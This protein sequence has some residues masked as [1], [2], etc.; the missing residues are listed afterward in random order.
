MDRNKPSV[1]ARVLLST[2]LIMVLR[3]RRNPLVWVEARLGLSP[4]PMERL[5]GIKGPFSGMTE[6]SHRLALLDMRSAI[7]AN[8]LV[9]I[10]WASV[11]V[12][13]LLWKF[14]TMKRRSDELRFFAIMAL[15]TLANNVA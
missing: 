8:P 5:F 14:P 3:V 7:E 12:M 10:F 2:A 9:I 15:A 11:A 6:A 4:S 13:I 1:A